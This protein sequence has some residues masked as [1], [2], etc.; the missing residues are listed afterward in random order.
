MRGRLRERPR[1]VRRAAGFGVFLTLSGALWWSQMGPAISAVLI[2]AG[3]VL[4]RIGFTREVLR[5]EPVTRPAR[6]RVTTE[7]IAIE[8]ES[9]I[10]REN[11]AQAY[12][13]PRRRGLGSVRGLDARGEVLF[14]LEVKNEPERSALLDALGCDVRHGRAAFRVSSPLFAT[15]ARSALMLVSLAL[16]LLLAYVLRSVEPAVYLLLTAFAVG[17]AALARRQTVEVG[18]DGLVVDWIGRPRFVSYAVIRAVEAQSLDVTV[19][20]EDG[21]RIHLA[22]G[23]GAG[24]ARIDVE[25]ARDA[26]IARIEDARR[27]FDGRADAGDFAARV[28][29]GAREIAEWR[30]A[31]ERLHSAEATGYRERVARGEDLWRVVEDA[32]APEDARAGAAVALRKEEGAPERLRIAADAVASPRLRVALEKASDLDVEEEALDEALEALAR[33]G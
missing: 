23:G 9:F 4:M 15:M 13:Q 25:L 19:T 6:V 7:G 29:R 28:G 20:L 8:D 24:S 14:D 10:P 12:Y 22:P 31:L 2:G 21:R 18:I 17:L 5:S 33:R 11:I 27:A 26:L 3:L 32:G 1:E 16:L 30:A